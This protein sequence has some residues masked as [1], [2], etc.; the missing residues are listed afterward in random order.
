[1]LHKSLWTE[2]VVEVQQVVVSGKLLRDKISVKVLNMRWRR[3]GVLKPVIKIH[4]C[5]CEACAACA[6]LKCNTAWNFPKLHLVRWMC[7]SLIWNSCSLQYF[8][9]LQVVAVSGDIHNILHH[10]GDISWVFPSYKEKKEMLRHVCSVLCR[11]VSNAEMSF[12]FSL[13]F[14]Y[15]YRKF[16]QPINIWKHLWEQRYSEEKVVWFIVWELWC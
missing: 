4:D 8:T 13:L 12:H 6:S 7:L 3:Q 16:T 14:C 11:C 5:R 1:M 9:K 2:M 10:F 15:S